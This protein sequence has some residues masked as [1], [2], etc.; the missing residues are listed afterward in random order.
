MDKTL[1]DLASAVAGIRDGMSVMIGG[2]GGS[3][4][5]IELIHA[6]IDR[7]LATGHPKG[8]T[9]INNNA[10]NGHVGLAA[11][12]EQGRDAARDRLRG[13]YEEDLARDLRAL[14]GLGVVDRVVEL[15]DTHHTRRAEGEALGADVS[16][17]DE[18]LRLQ[19]AEL[20]AAGGVS[21]AALEALRTRFADDA[22]VVDALNQALG[23]HTAAANDNAAAQ[24]TLADVTRLA[25]RELDAQIR[26]QEEIRRSAVAVVDAIADTRRRLALDPGLSVL[27]PQEQ[28]DEA[29]RHFE[30]LEARSLAGDQA[31]QRELAPAGE[32]YLKLARDFY[33]SSED[34]A[35]IFRRVD[36]ALRGTGD[37]ASR[38][39]EL[40][41]QQLEELKGLR[42]ALTGELG[43][44]PNPDAD[45]GHNPT[46]NRILARLTGYAGDFGDGGFGS[47]RAGLS[48]ELNALIDAIASSIHFAEGGVMTGSGPLSLHRYAG[49]GVASSPQLALFGEGRLP[50]AFVPLPDGRTIPVTVSAAANDRAPPAVDDGAARRTAGIEALVGE[51][52][53]LR[54]ELAGLRAENAGLRRG[55]ERLAA[56]MGIGRAA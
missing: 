20:I 37:V 12:I 8:L 18:L 16:G 22:L 48:A 23:R 13:A 21:A 15:V 29:R 9:V 26:E 25:T 10:G 51:T 2:F 5:P 1:P 54:D 28:L 56:G 38:Q 53:R 31:A 50:E 33:A 39:L 46:R 45:F 35:R 6:L 4:A 30:D 11:L 41:E 14:Q 34:Y 3:G 19:V 32:A 47:F 49:G 40:A 55:L 27:S 36:D 43:G 17:L 42:R 24:M 44:L 7:Y 52:R